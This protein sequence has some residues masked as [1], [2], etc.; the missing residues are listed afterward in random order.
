MLVVLEDLQL[1]ASAQVVLRVQAKEKTMTQVGQLSHLMTYHNRMNPIQSSLIHATITIQ[2]E[3]NILMLIV[4]ANPHNVTT[5]VERGHQSQM[6][7]TNPNVA[8]AK[9]RITHVTHKKLNAAG[10]FSASAAL[11]YF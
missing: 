6:N 2:E 10:V 1:D 4:T 3:H 5:G 9:K 7:L 8:I 11:T